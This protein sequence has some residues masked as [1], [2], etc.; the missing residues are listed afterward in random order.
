MIRIRTLARWSAVSLAMTTP[1]PVQGEPRRSLSGIARLLE[2][3]VVDLVETWRGKPD[4]E[5][6]DLGG[7]AAGDLGAQIA[8]AVGAVEVR[9]ERL[10][11][12]YARHG[13]QPGGHIVAPRLDVDD[14]AAA[15][16]P[17]GQFGHRAG[18]CD[19]AA[20][21]QRHPVANAL[22]LV[23]MMRRQQHR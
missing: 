19:A 1:R 11:P 23:E 16:H 9:A 5:Q 8:L 21:E 6:L 7:K 18:E 12:D 17:P 3:A 14:I 2:I 20:V 22:H 13:A 15:E 4:A 10:H